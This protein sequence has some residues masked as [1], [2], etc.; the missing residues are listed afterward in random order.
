MKTALLVGITCLILSVQPCSAEWFADVYTGVSFTDKHDFKAVSTEAGHATYND[1][2]FDKGLAYGLRFGRY[3]DAVPFLG[4]GVD[5]FS[6]TSN[7]GPQSVRVDGCPFAGTCV[8][9]TKITL[10]SY[11]ISTMSLS[12]DVFLRLPLFKSADAPGGR[13][14]PYILGGAPVFLTSF[15]PRN[16]HLFRNGDGDHDITFGYKAGAGVAVYVFKNLMIFGEYRFT[17]VNEQS[18]DVRDASAARSHLRTELESHTGLVGL[19]ARW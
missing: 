17:H 9:N 11:D 13:V 2:D 5:Y 10:G 15:T 3:F 16:T 7:V 18:F 6:F 8:S 4:V 1:V 19:S 12:L 14:Q